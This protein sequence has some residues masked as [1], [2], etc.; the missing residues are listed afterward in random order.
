M[1]FSSKVCVVTGAASGIGLAIARE[2]GQNGGKIVLSDMDEAKG[3]KAIEELNKE[4]IECLFIKSD[5][6]KENE[7]KHLVEETVKKF[8]SLNVM[9]ANAGINIEGEPHSM[10]MSKWQKVIDVNLNGVFLCNKYAA[11]QMLKQGTGG[12]I[13]NLGSIHSFV[14]REG[15]TPYSASKGGVDMLTKMMGSTY[16]SRGI[17][18][19]MICPGYI[20]TPLM[21]TVPPEIQKKLVSMHPIGRLGEAYEV[22]KAAAFL[23]SDDASFITGTSLL[24]DGGYTS[25]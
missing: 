1:K 21:E 8:G 16:A 17:R 20:K 6:T 7:V 9:V 10:E 12:S 24:V 19:N 4:N 5:V 13:I 25:V 3:K 11:D 15:L 18:T 22:A 23:A 2:L 14:G